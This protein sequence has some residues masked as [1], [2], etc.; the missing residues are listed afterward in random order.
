ML[1]GELILIDEAADARF[2]ALLASRPVRA[3][4]PAA[5]LRQAVP[6]RF[7][8]AQRLEQSSR[9]RRRYPPHVV[10]GHRRALRAKRCRRLT[11]V[12]HRPAQD[13][14]AEI[15]VLLKPSVNDPQ[16]IS[17][18]ERV[19]D[20]RVR[21]RAGR[22][23]GQVDPGPAQRQRSAGGRGRPS[24]ACARSCWPTR[25]SRRSRSASTKRQRAFPERFEH[26]AGTGCAPSRIAPSGG[27]LAVVVRATRDQ[28]AQVARH[29]QVVRLPQPPG[30]H[31][32]ASSASRPFADQRREVFALTAA[33]GRV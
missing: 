5:E 8:G 24:S 6:A 9:R 30:I 22:A 4:R 13:W 14:L 19:A 29:A 10:D 21:R 2:V 23:G 1:D 12:S 17:I 33:A 3:R 18:R 28:H 32:Q 26:L 20:A 15:R 31:C 7:S 11:V 27:A 25:S 16:G